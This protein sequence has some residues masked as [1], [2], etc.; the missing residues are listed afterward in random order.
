MCEYNNKPYWN[1][2]SLCS[3][4]PN[5][6]YVTTTTTNIKVEK[7]NDS[8]IHL[9]TAKEYEDI[10]NKI[11]F[12]FTDQWS[13]PK[14]QCPICNSEMCKNLNIA[15]LTY[16]AQYEYRCNRCGYIEHQYI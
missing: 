6:S 3:S 14:Y 13:K 2:V 12:Q 4:R 16:P 7:D 9:P 10:A 15:L 8:I 5:D 1:V 11:V